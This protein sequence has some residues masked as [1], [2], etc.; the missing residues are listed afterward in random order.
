MI[1]CHLYWWPELL[2][3]QL[4][5]LWC[6]LRCLAKIISW[7]DGVTLRHSWWF[8]HRCVKDAP[9][10]FHYDTWALFYDI[11]LH[12]FD[13]FAYKRLH[14][15]RLEICLQDCTPYFIAEH[16]LWVP[17]VLLF[18]QVEI[19]RPFLLR[20]KDAFCEDCE[21]EGIHAIV[22]VDH[23]IF[24]CNVSHPFSFLS[25]K[26]FPLTSAQFKHQIWRL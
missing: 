2:F 8:M 13:Y 11:K 6:K 21:Q 24:D 1:V 23:T 3:Q 9:G 22:G 19:V 25:H 12:I 15:C 17:N 20:S 14:R 7:Q 10:W 16:I 26:S 5:S 4:T 18:N